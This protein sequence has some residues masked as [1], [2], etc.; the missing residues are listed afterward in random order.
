[1]SSDQYESKEVSI[2]RNFFYEKHL[3]PLIRDNYK[4]F[5]GHDKQTLELVIVDDGSE[6]LRLLN[7]I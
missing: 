4:R 3:R 2:G 1:M 5:K 6:D 7:L